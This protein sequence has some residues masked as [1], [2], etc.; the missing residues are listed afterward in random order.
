VVG[1][2]G[3]LFGLPALIAVAG[4]TPLTYTMI[5]VQAGVA[6]FGVRLYLSVST[7]PDRVELAK[8]G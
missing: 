5:A 1:F 3:L 8:T 6:A 7:S 4:G 2:D